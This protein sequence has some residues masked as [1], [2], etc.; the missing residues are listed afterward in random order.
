MEVHS[1]FEFCQDC[2]LGKKGFQTGI[3]LGGYEID[4]AIL[5]CIRFQEG[6]IDRDGARGAPV[7]CCDIDWENGTFNAAVH[8][9]IVSRV[10][11]SY[12]LTHAWYDPNLY[13]FYV[14]VVDPA[15][16]E[17]RMELDQFRGLLGPPTQAAPSTE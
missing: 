8:P 5:S 12:T 16:Q 6:L 13:R 11:V 1:F 3:G 17:G 4:W 14:Q 9:V 10:G 7:L 2:G 15:G